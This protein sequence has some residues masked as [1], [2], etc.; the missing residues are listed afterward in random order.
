MTRIRLGGIKILEG[1]CYLKASN[2]REEGALS[3]ICSQMTEE[4]VNLSLMTHLAGSELGS[5]ETVVCVES[6]DGLCGCSVLEAYAESRGRVRLQPDTCIISIFPHDLKP[7]VAGV[8][9]QALARMN[10]RPRGFAS[11]PSALSVLVASKEQKDSIE[12]IFQLFELGGYSSPVD[13]YAAYKG[14]EQVLKEI[15]CTYQEDVIKV[16]N[17][18]CHKEL[19]LWYLDVPVGDLDR[20]GELL[21]AVGETEARMAFLVAQSRSPDRLRLAFTLES[22]IRQWA[23]QRMETVFPGLARP[24]HAPAAALFLHGPHFGDRYGIANALVQA[25]KAAGVTPLGISCA[26]SSLSVVIPLDRLSETIQMLHLYF[27]IPD[28]RSEADQPR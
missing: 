16:Y 5:P 8:V 10:I 13:W 3:S 4:R 17:I 11:S 22:R 28:I 2:E 14:R 20:L 23:K 1:R 24:H 9:M 19:D 7:G 27:Q 12:A 18:T 25:L 26:V 15:I 21:A 6:S